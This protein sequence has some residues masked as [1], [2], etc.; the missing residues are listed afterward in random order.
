[1]DYTC[2]NC[3]ESVMVIDD[4]ACDRVVS[5]S[6]WMSMRYRDDTGSFYRRKTRRSR[7]SIPVK[8]WFRC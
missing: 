6:S 7:Y 1:M 4:K 2:G 8:T 5:P 3:V